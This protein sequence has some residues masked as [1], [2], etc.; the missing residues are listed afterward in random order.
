MTPYTFDR[1]PDLEEQ[2]GE[3]APKVW[4]AFMLEDM[5]ASRYWSKLFTVFPEFQ[6]TFLDDNGAVVANA[7]TIPFYWDGT[8]MNLPRGWDEVIEWGFADHAAGRK[9]NTL[10]A[11]S[12]ELVPEYQGKG[13]SAEPLLQMRR[14]GAAHGFGSLVAPVRPTLKSRYP[15]V[16]IEHY[17]YWTRPDGLPFDPWLRTHVRIGGE[18]LKLAP[19]SM[20]IPGTVARWEEW[21]GLSFPVSGRY[22][23]EHALEPISIDRE[24]DLGVYIEPNVW[25]RHSLASEH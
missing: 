14:I 20:Y 6:S 21:S 15:L 25:V 5:V 8:L 18:I 9:P 7:F 24:A 19:Q 13:L 16:P 23:V 11:L 4:P 3:V 22:I 17:A 2:M 1:R 12:A 10:S